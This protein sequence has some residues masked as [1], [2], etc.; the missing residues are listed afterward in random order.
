MRRTVLLFLVMT[1]GCVAEPDPDVGASSEELIGD[2]TLAEV[3]LGRELFNHGEFDGNGRSCAS[4]HTT[5]ERA[6]AVGYGRARQD[7]LGPIAAAL[8]GLRFVEE[9]ATFDLAPAF[10][11]EVFMLDPNDPLFRS[12]DANGGSGD[13]YS[14]LLNEALIRIHLTLP[15]NVTVD[16]CG[17]PGTDCIVMPN[18]Q[19]RVT[20]LRSSPQVADTAL[21]EQRDDLF[22]RTESGLMWDGREHTL[23]HQAQSALGDHFETT[24][25]LSPTESRAIAA[26]QRQLFTSV[27]TARMAAYDEDPGLPPCT[28]PAECRG[29]E[30]FVVQ[31]ISVNDME[32]RGLCAACHSG[33][34]LNRTSQF[35]PLQPPGIPLADGTCPCG[36]FGEHILPDGTCPGGHMP[37]EGPVDI[38]GGTQ[39][40]FHRVSAMTSERERE[41][42]PQRTF[43]FAHPVW[44]NVAIRSHDPGRPLVTGDPCGDVP[45][46]CAV[47]PGATIVQFRIA[48]LRGVG[49]RDRLLH[50][51]AEHTLR[52]QVV[53]LQQAFMG[54]VP[55]FQAQGN[56]DAEAFILSDQD[57]DDITAYLS[58]L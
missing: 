35:N 11:Q 39:V 20:V 22:G 47:A 24:H 1:M 58:R 12:L 36:P 7:G 42:M 27:G 48:S 5:V 3:A 34:M 43:R 9:Y 30:F 8:R 40:C 10:A 51:S 13:D 4:C 45:A 32:H 14:M 19:H 18:G 2:T 50:D 56:P 31:P 41:G 52:D 28:T 26:F 55:L 57:V 54:F 6:Y 15:P 38:G 33:P 44:G 49:R 46:A 16:D 17:Q 37:M 53:S 23:E 25:V 21:L 29:R